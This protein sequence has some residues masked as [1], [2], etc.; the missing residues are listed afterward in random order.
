M[1]FAFKYNH[2]LLDVYCHHS[3]D[4][5]FI[6]SCLSNIGCFLSYIIISSGAAIKLIIMNKCVHIKKIRLSII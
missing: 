6:L 4:E 3:L 5:S 2:P 1:K